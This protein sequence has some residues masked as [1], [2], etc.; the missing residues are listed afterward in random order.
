METI[1]IKA[2]TSVASEITNNPAEWEW[3]VNALSGVRHNSRVKAAYQLAMKWGQTIPRRGTWDALTE[4]QA[5]ALAVCIL[6]LNGIGGPA[7][8]AWTAA[9]EQAARQLSNELV[10]RF[11]GGVNTHL[12][13]EENGTA[14][15]NILDYDDGAV[16]TVRVPFD[17]RDAE[18]RLAKR[19]A[20]LLVAAE[21][22]L[23]NRTN[24][25]KY[26][27]YASLNQEL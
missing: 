10:H 5:T 25:V 24:Q 26:V 27:S 13:I 9:I 11:K 19:R 12:Y 1:T 8:A 21:N 3:L 2:C 18:W 4:Q 20:E 17:W 15:I 14:A 22:L 6:D 7:G 23:A 16:A